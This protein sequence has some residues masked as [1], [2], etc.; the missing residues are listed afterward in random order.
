MPYYVSSMNIEHEYADLTGEYR[1]FEGLY[2]VDTFELAETKQQSF[3][4][5]TERNAERVER[6]RRSPITVVISNPP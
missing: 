2:L 6:Q 1:P 3:A 5:R 4:A